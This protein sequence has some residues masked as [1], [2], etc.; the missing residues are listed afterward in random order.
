MTR[1][2]RVS[3]RVKDFFTVLAILLGM[4]LTILAKERL[5]GVGP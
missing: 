1:V 4:L 2:R 3:E 5:E